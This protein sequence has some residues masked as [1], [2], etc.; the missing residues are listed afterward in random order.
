M[1]I[2]GAL[3]RSRWLAWAV[4]L[5][6]RLRWRRWLG[7]SAILLLST[8][9]MGSDA[10]DI[11]PTTRATAAS[12]FSL[13]EWVAR[14]LT[15]KALSGLFDFLPGRGHSEEERE[16]AIHTYFELG[17]QVRRI[18]GTLAL[19]EARG[20]VGGEDNPEAVALEERLDELRSQRDDLS[21]VVE[22][23]LEKAVA[24]VLRDQDLDRNW[25]PFEPLFPPVSFRLERLPKLIVV[26][27]RERIAT[28]DTHLLDSDLSI[29]EREA[30]ETTVGPDQGRS[31][32]VTGLGGLAT[33]P[34]LVSDS[35]SLRF[36]LQTIVHE[37]LHQYFFFHPLGQSYFDSADLTTLNET[38]ADIGG[39][40]LGDLVFLALG[41]DIPLPAPG[42]TAQPQ[43]DSDRF[44]FNKTMRETRLRTD[45]LLAAGLIDE[46]EAYMEERRM[47]FV[48][49]G[50]PIRLLNQAYF[51]FHGTY[52][53]NAAS[54]SPIAGQ[55][56]QVR[57]DSA[58]VGRFI[59]RVRGFGDYQSF[60][61]YVDS[62]P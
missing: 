11:S 42:N 3:Q 29:A 58:T 25:G 59:K 36:A 4:C 5:P 19:S 2:S 54:V 48:E 18:E 61:E 28:L 31:A 33:F 6:S 23:T 7:F 50:Y 14:N 53:E 51:A 34:S 27:P 37:W 16:A 62:V 35:Q 30:L 1:Q 40:E 38:A 60:L 8:V 55:L 39:K 43:F 41:G 24:D 10:L 57:D 20:G 32:L 13:E 15:G 49:N 9:M 52:A 45:E 56:R 26:S 47:I 17:E 46:A 21:G 12:S 22:S 44:D